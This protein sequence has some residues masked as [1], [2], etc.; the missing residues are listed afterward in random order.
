ML[1]KK[2]NLKIENGYLYAFRNHD[3]RGSGNYKFNSF[4]KKGEV[5]KDWHCDLN[6]KNKNSYGFGIWP[7][8]NTPVRVPLKAWGTAVYEDPDGKG[9]HMYQYDNPDRT[10]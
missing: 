2:H 3:K 4:Y 8:G 1:N 5:Y 10:G 9:F 6:P 7:K